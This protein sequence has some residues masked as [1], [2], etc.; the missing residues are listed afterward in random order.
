LHHIIHYELSLQD[1]ERYEENI[2]SAYLYGYWHGKLKGLESRMGLTAEILNGIE[3]RAADDIRVGIRYTAVRIGGRVGVARTTYDKCDR[4]IDGGNLIGSKVA[5]LVHSERSIEATI[6]TASINAQLEPKGRIRGG[7]I[8]TMIL[9]MAGRFESIGV[10]GFF[11][12][13]NQLEG[14]VHV[15]EK[16]PAPG[17]L[18]ASEA[19]NYL[20]KCDLVVIT[21]SAFVNGTLEH[22]LELS[23]GYTMVIGPST[24]LSPVLFDFG[25]DMLAGIVSKDEGILDIVSQGGGTRDFMK[26]ADAIVMERK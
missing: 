23:G 13:V 3:D 4:Q 17:C 6:G 26:M 5:G 18:P 12:F 7:N 1:D 10:V 22:L 19:D 15:F 24:P 14:D 20:P 8:F 9:E 25:A 11:P 2:C 21:G 16:R